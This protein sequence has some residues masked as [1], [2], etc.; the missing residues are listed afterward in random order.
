VRRFA[1]RAAVGCGEK[2]DAGLQPV[3]ALRAEPSC[4]CG[5]SG[6]AADFYGQLHVQ[7]REGRLDFF[8]LRRM[9]GSGIRRITRSCTPRRRANSELSLAGRGSPGRAAVSAPARAALAPDADRASRLRARESLPCGTTGLRDPIRERLWLLPLPRD[10]LCH[11]WRPAGVRRT[12]PEC[13]AAAA[14]H[15]SCGIRKWGHWFTSS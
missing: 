9:L 11:R 1:A 2:S 12:R 5:P 4:P 6:R 14:G 8:R 7:S 13:A 15:K 10:R 3:S